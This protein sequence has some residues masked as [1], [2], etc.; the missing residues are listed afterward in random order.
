MFY[1]LNAY[2]KNSPNGVSLAEDQKNEKVKTVEWISSTLLSQVASLLL[3]I[4]FDYQRW[5]LHSATVEVSV[6]INEGL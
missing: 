3:Q 5:P 6:H 1:Q 4:H 2:T